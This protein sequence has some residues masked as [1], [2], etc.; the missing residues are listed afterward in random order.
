MISGN[1]T[2][3]VS[4]PRS[5]WERGRD[6]PRPAGIFR[7]F[8]AVLPGIGRGASGMHSNA[9]RGNESL[10]GPSAQVEKFQEF[11]NAPLASV[12][13]IIILSIAKKA[14]VLKCAHR[15]FFIDIP[16][17]LMQVNHIRA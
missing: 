12:A 13:L 15:F 5:A 16:R 3:E 6:A 10:N 17:Y 11:M 2:S 8:A 4:F 9:E 14:S 1:Q 7:V